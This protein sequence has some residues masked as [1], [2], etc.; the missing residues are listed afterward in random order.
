MVQERERKADPMKRFIA[1]MIAVLMLVVTITAMAEEPMDFRSLAGLDEIEQKLNAGITIDSLYYTDGYG[2]STSEFRTGDPDEIQKIWQ[3]LNQI[4]VKGRTN[5]GITDWCP[6]VVFYFSDGT[7]DNVTFEA[8]WLSLPTPWPQA[9]Y[10]LENDDAFWNLTAAL[11][12]KYESS[13]HPKENPWTGS[14]DGRYC[15]GVKDV[16]DDHIDLVLYRE[17]DYNRGEIEEL[18]PGDTVIV[19]GRTYTV[20][21]LLLHGSYD[22]DGDGEVDASCVTVADREMHQELLDSLEIVI[23]C[24]YEDRPDTFELSSFELITAEE[25]D[26]YIAFEV[27]DDSK[28]RAV[29]NDWNPCTYVGRIT[30]Q[31]PLPEGFVFTDYTD[32]EGGAQEFLEHIDSPWYTPYNTEAWFENGQLVKVRHSD[33]P[34]GP[35]D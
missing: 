8:H 23:D 7:T 12:N 5:E 11:K 27:L 25:F 24:D 10:E 13:V 28:C 14:W 1:L 17:D 3:A 4:T 30:V 32:N 33:Y 34:M 29:V 18:L 22:S 15:I 35:E 9:N 19:N 20:A 31:L 21:A 16:T 2:F 6:Q 26:G